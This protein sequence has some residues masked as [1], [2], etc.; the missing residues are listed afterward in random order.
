MVTK[1][2]FKTTTNWH[3]TGMVITHIILTVTLSFLLLLFINAYESVNGAGYMHW[4]ALVTGI[5]G[6][7]SQATVLINQLIEDLS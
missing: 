5:A 6:L 4:T 2:T 3:S 1:T 7:S